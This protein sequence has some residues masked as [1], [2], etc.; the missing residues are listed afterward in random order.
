MTPRQRIERADHETVLR[1]CLAL[2]TGREPDAAMV[3]VLGGESAQQY[4]DTYW[5]RVWG[6]RGLLWAWDDRAMP[7]LAQALTDEHWRV[8]EMALKVVARH[9]LDLDPTP[10]L[11]DDNA[12]VRAAA[13]RCASTCS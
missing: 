1:A 9:G 8:R 3:A 5:G 4:V 13:H 10:L 7:A 2:L 12:R 6:V 11:D